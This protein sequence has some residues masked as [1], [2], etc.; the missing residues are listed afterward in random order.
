MKPLPALELVRNFDALPKKDKYSNL[1]DCLQYGC[2]SL[3]EGRRM[4][5]LKPAVD[6][7][8]VRYA[9]PRRSLRRVLA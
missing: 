3:G 9:Q 7:K 2:L 6:V 1:C 5:G 8:P 4:V